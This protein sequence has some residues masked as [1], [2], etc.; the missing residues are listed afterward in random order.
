MRIYTPP[1][2]A[3][4]ITVT[5]VTCREGEDVKENGALFNY[6][7]RAKREVWD[8]DVRENVEKELDHRADFESEVEGKVTSLNVQVGQVMNGRV[9][10]AEIE[11]PCKHEVQFG[12][13]C[14]D[15]GRDM[16]TVSYSTTVKNTERA[17]INTVHGHTALL[18]S[19]AEASR[20]DEEAKRRLLDS[21]KLSLVVDLDQT[22][23]QATV[24][25]TV[26]E[27][28][29]DET[30]PNHDAVKHVRKFQLVDEGLAGRGTW[31][32]I[33][34]RPGLKEFLQII[35]QF[36]ELH[37]YTMA[38][39]A[40]AKE[41]ANIVDPDHKLFADR[42]LS[43]DENGSM[44][45]KNLKR[46]FPVDTK[47][48]V[49]ID[50]RGDVW[51][52]SPNLVKVY[53]YDFFVGIGDINSA[54][55]PKQQALE[56]RPKQS[57]KKEKGGKDVKTSDTPEAS[58]SEAK[59]DGESSSAASKKSTPASTPLTTNGDVSAVDRMVSMAGKQDEGSLDEKAEE[60]DKTIA[61]QL[62]DR[63]LLQKQ[64]ILDAADEEAKAS[65]AAEAAVELLSENGD[66]RDTPPPE[67][68]KYRHN[69][70]HDD[71][72]ELEHLTQ[73]LRNIHQAYF[74]SYDRDN[75]TLKSSRVAEL[76]PGH[77]K[78]RSIDELEHIPDAAIIMSDMKNRVLAGVHIVFSGVVPLGVD[79]HNHDLGIWAKS[80]GANISENI[81]KRTTHVIA[82]AERRTAKVRQAAKRGGRIAIVN[83]NWLYAC[84]SQWKRVDEDVYRI[85]TD[86]TTNGKSGK[87]LP[88]GVEGK[89]YSEVVLS[90]SEEEA[91]QTEDETD[92]S[93]TTGSKTPNGRLEIDTDVDELEQY[94]PDDQRK[95]SSPTEEER[96]E[97][98]GS[99]MNEVDEFMGSE[100]DDS[101][102]E[103][104]RTATA[105]DG[106]KTP[107]S[108]RKRKRD[109]VVDGG[110]AS[111][112]TDG[113]GEGDE[114]ESRLQKRKKEALARTTS[115][116]NVANVPST[117]GSTPAAEVS[118]DPGGESKEGGRDDADGE[119]E[120]E[121]DDLEAALAA[122]MERQ[123]EEDGDA[124]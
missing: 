107:P 23:I 7:Y 74:D 102:T 99:I 10:V 34:L 82:S 63:P 84:F 48:V 80:F 119:Q 56:A 43:R 98:W 55:L 37:I 90:S 29:E 75:T 32:Y 2:L 71:D 53:A 69:L 9:L 88:D 58:S 41:I 25:P 83:Q 44:N 114:G 77:S 64:K 123:S 61:A 60:Q 17:T 18:V 72:T 117:N 39:R 113:D 118:V 15:C 91:A 73:S 59:S 101:D 65:P 33:K 67:G 52:W 76:R 6:Q 62:A 11:E 105:S 103:S 94:A 57:A 40:Y 79:I 116:T 81:G 36:Y 51:S 50:D 4:P 45:S 92:D 20:A 14:A 54:F 12:G 1:G 42:I 21:R 122:E 106:T 8:D 13:M 124:A 31:Y 93:L 86:A 68:S 5:K 85:H 38:T 87:D 120:E 89:P 26:G 16:N 95:D 66:K 49:I 47:M 35:A 46:L 111:D 108:Q 121:E 70:L 78:K 112:A 3:Y 28:Q 115:L 22:V 96:D 104:V 19:Q 110:E 109:A 97:D 24:D 100:A 30:N 27:W